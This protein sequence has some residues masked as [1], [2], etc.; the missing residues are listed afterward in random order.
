M[1]NDAAIFCYTTVMSFRE[2]LRKFFKGDILDDPATLETYSHDA[3]LFE[4]KPQMVVFPKDTGDVEKLVAWAAES[5]DKKISLTARSAGT[6]M[7]G[8]PLTESIVADFTRYF[9]H[10]I[11]IGEDYAI[12]Q[13]GVFYRDFERETLKHD[14][15]MPSYPASR[16]ICTV[17]GMAA[18]NSGGEKTLAY[19]KTEQYVTGLKVVLRDGKE[20][21]FGPVSKAELEK[22][23]KKK[24]L[25]GEIYRRVYKLVKD[26]FELLQKAKPRVS[27]NSAGY[28]LW[29]VWDGQTFDLTKLFVGSQGTLG[30]ITEIKYRLIHPKKHSAMV[31]L[32]LKD[33]EQLAD[34]IEKV[35]SF[36]PES[37]ESYDD[38]TM[39]LAIRFLPE[40]LKTMKAKNL[41][42]LGWQ[43]LPELWMAITGGI[44]KLV[45]IAEFTDDSEQA[46]QEKA[47]Q[48]AAALKQFKIPIRVMKNERESR[49]YWVIRRESFN[50][51]RRHVRGRRTAPFIDDMVVQPEKLP[52]FLP[53]LNEILKNYPSLVYTVAGHVGDGNF[54][55]IP[56]MDMS[57][58]KSREIIPELS[59]RVYKLVFEFGGSTTGEHNDGLIRSPYLKEMYGEKVY[60][61]FEEVKQIFDPEGI[62]NP[63]KKVGSSLEY[64]LKHLVKNS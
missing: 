15:L 41:L 44:P 62:F 20:Y 60:K 29:N 33:T 31:A 36:K 26:N 19:G 59:E 12:T 42:A 23:I 17:G 61:L 39:K 38:N 6:D 45:L 40:L 47:G 5:K 22:R 4:I 57:D 46:A 28:F 32:F 35:L 11:K 63:G 51:L 52:V 9:N 16:E 14:L 64:A 27:K 30:L 54:H 3:S 10:I 55:I 50:L 24:T 7:S 37:F 48:A 56:L 58:P 25:E 49:K 2:P 8:G 43:F 1:E 34:I 53:K 18:N 21:A 13:P